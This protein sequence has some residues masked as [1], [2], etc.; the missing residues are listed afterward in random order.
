M[1]NAKFYNIETLWGT[2]LYSHP[3]GF[4]KKSIEL[5]KTHTIP[6]Y[7]KLVP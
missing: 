6:R 1:G 7:G 4:D 5:K 2:L 3:M